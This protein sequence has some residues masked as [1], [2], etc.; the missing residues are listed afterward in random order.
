MLSLDIL[1]CFCLDKS[2][3]P[4]IDARDMS[5]HVFNLLLYLQFANTHTLDIHTNITAATSAH[6]SL[7]Y[8]ST[9]EYIYFAFMHPFCICILHVLSILC[10]L[11]VGCIALFGIVCLL[12]SLCLAHTLTLVKPGCSWCSYIHT[13]HLTNSCKAGL[14]THTLQWA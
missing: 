9:Y 10:L 4:L 11:S 6:R 1:L 3:P 2:C 5:R 12:T 14:V 7:P 8:P 13:L